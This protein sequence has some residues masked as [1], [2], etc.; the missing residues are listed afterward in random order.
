MKRFENL[1]R[2]DHTGATAGAIRKARRGGEESRIRTVNG[3]MN[4]NNRGTV[5]WE[6]QRTR[7]HLRRDE[8]T[9]LAFQPSPASSY[10]RDRTYCEA[11]NRRRYAETADISKYVIIT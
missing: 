9:A 3:N 7:H 11:R 1:R 10:L 8:R 2:V 4:R 6:R 5:Q